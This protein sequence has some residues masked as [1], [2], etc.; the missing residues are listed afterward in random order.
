MY[1]PKTCGKKIGSVHADYLGGGL[2]GLLK[3]LLCQINVNKK[4]VF[5]HIS[6][7]LHTATPCGFF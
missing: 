1:S 4:I 5:N 6:W 3:I 2:L 7:F